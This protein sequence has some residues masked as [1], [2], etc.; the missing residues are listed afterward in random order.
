MSVPRFTAERYPDGLRC[1]ECGQ[2]FIEGQPI[3]EIP[4]AMMMLDDECP[5]VCV[6]LWCV[7]CSLERIGA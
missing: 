2:P 6:S 3:A 4:E 5:A 7:Y 1:D